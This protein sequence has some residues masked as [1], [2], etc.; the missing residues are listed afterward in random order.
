[1]TTTPPAT[2]SRLRRVRWGRWLIVLAVAVSAYGAW[3]ESAK[4]RAIRLVEEAGFKWYE[5]NIV[6]EVRDDWRNLFN[7]ESWASD[8]RDL[9][10][11]AGLSPIRINTEDLR[12]ALVRL[13]VRDLEL[14]RMPEPT[15]LDFI[16]GIDSIRDLFIVDFPALKNISA[17]R[18]LPHLRGIYIGSC[19]AL[20]D[21]TGIADLPALQ[22]LSIYGKSGTFSVRP[23]TNLPKLAM[24]WLIRVPV[25]RDL[26][27][28]SG[29][30]ALKIL[31]IDPASDVP[32]E[33]VAALNEQIAAIKKARPALRTDFSDPG[34]VFTPLR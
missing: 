23:L 5:R 10:A 22:G 12:S 32:A 7:K 13:R 29:L 31:R 16:R 3:M 18:G 34:K 8:V 1:M 30:P 2:K 33:E 11:R 25:P 27:T 19:P 4:R 15:D 26:S 9:K 28:V 6:T 21:L 24:I 20:T 17:L 14:S